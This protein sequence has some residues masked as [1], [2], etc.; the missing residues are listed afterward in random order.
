[1]SRTSASVPEPSLA[2]TAYERIRADILTCDLEPGAEVTEAEL[3]GRYELGKAP[4]RVALQRLAQD[5]LV[6]AL[7][8]RGH[9]IAPITLKDIHDLFELRLLIEPAMAARAARKITKADLKRLR[10]LT[11]ESTAIGEPFSS[12]GA[13]FHL[14]LIEL[15]G[16]RR[17]RDVMA[18]VHDQLERVANLRLA[19]SDW[20]Q[21]VHD[22]HGII[23]ACERGDAVEVERL[24]ASHIEGARRSI[25]DVILQ[26]D[27][28][29]SI[30]IGRR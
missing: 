11:V 1:M 16:N 17:A 30:E 15:A 5:G 26:S 19:G 28:V 7:P 20:D 10:E 8:R 13:E 2:D 18:Q 25:V 23:D 21:M 24:V 27:A 9:L 12:P 14:F 4:I 3:A 29:Q 22:H 6:Q